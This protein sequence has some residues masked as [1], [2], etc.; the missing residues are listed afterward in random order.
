MGEHLPMSGRPALGIDRGNDALAAEFFRR[1]AH[2]FGTIDGGGVDRHLVCASEQQTADILDHPHAAADGQRHETLLGGAANHAVKRVAVF[3]AGGDIE[4][5]QLVGA[6]AVVEARLS[7]RIAG[8]DKID[9]V[10]ALDD[11][12]VLDIETGDDP[13]LQHGGCSATKRNAASGSI[14]PS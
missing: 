12:P 2:E 9:E 11:P 14:R 3:R 1:F 8:I 6:L 7:H 5:A 10:D 4:K 13:H